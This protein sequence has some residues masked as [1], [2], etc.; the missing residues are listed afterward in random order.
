MEVGTAGTA[1]TAASTV[2]DVLARAGPDLLRPL[3][4]SG[5]L[6]ARTVTGVCIYDAAAGVEALPGELLLAVGVDPAPD[7]LMRVVDYAARLDLT[8]IILRMMHPVDPAVAAHAEARGMALLAAPVTPWAHLAA[9]VRAAVVSGSPSP[10]SHQGRAALGDLFAFAADV[11]LEVGGAVTIEDPSY[12]V[13]AYSSVQDEVDEPRKQTILGRAV[14]TVFV[15]LL[16]ERGILQALRST[17]EIV[18]TEAVPELGLGPRWAVGIHA[19]GEFLG[20]LWVAESGGALLE[21]YA[22]ALREAARAG[23]LHLL[24]HRLELQTDQTRAHDV[25][26]EL[27]AGGTPADALATSAGLRL[28][29]RYLVIVLESR[30]AVPARARL[31]RTVATYCATLGRRSLVIEQGPRVYAV[32]SFAG[33]G[34]LDSVARL[35]IAAE[36]AWHGAR[37]TGLEVLASVGSLA[38]TTREI[39]SSRRQA[40]SA[41]RVLR[42]RMVEGC[43]TAYDDVRSQVTLLDLVDLVGERPGLREGKVQALVEADRSGVLVATLSAYLDCFGDVRVAAKR[44]GVHPNTFRYRLRRLQEQ[45]RLNLA[46]PAERLVAAL[47]L[48]ALPPP[49]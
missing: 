42:H 28:G 10:S 17:D 38:E 14:P 34:E 45:V 49:R 23:A 5:A 19:A 37:A 12:R 43:V 46:D 1:H 31:A 26:R 3:T 6:L 25:G 30:E 15:L 48:R 2:G 29:D 41:L 18:V 21:D 20:S 7:A 11:A 22:P 16:R 4:T 27:L 24:H 13:L 39:A 44:L 33:A 47:Q 35:R 36:A 9:V 40:D 8:G 32:V